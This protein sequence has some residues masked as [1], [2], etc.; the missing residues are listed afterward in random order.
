MTDYDLV[1]VGA[2]SGNMLPSAVLEGMRVAIIEHDRF[3][4]TCLNR[5]C[6]PSKM[7]VYAAEIA[8]TVRHAGRY[9]IRAELVGADWPAI[10]DRV[11]TR[12]DAH[13]EETLVSRRRSGVDVYLGEA[14]FV[15]PRVLEVDGHQ[16]RGERFV[17]AVGSRPTIPE[18]DGLADVPFHTSD[19]IMRIDALPASMV[20]VGGGPVAAE[21]SHVFGAFGTEITI[22]NRGRLL[23]GGLDDDLAQRFTERY[24]ARF[25]VR[26]DTQVARVERTPNGVALHLEGATGPGVVEAEAL[27]VATGR[28][29]NSDVL[30]VAAGGIT[31]D[32]HGHV[33]T[34]AT[35]ATSVPGVWAIGDVAN[36]FELKHLANAEMRLVLHN[37]LHADDTRR[38]NFPVMPSAVFADPLVA[39]AGPTE[40]ALQAKGTPFVVA[41]RDY[42]DTAYGWALEDTTSFVKLIA[43]PI[44]RRLLAAHLIGPQAATLIQPLVQA[45]YLDNTVEQLAHDVLYIHPAPTEVIAQALL[46]LGRAQA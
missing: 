13:S 9:G 6:I 38:A 31:V 1:I 32:E 24:S 46:E 17:L 5:G 8:E 18:I 27:L 41:R 43:D 26:L 3:G 16:L 29:P 33:V 44:T 15:G 2:G 30:D 42:S 7:L 22:V 4:G 45:I 10:R 35:Y 34:D 39:T 19:T 28:V 14:R 21:M 36:H 12:I 20:I 11:F 25:D 37:I 40:R 23:L